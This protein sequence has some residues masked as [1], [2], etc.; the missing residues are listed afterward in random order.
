MTIIYK[1]NSLPAAMEQLAKLVPDLLQSKKC[2]ESLGSA[3]PPKKYDTG[4]VQR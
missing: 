4:K 2:Q 3:N 1:F